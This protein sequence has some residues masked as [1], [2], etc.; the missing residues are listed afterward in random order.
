MQQGGDRR[1]RSASESSSS[2]QN[3]VAMS[4]SRYNDGPRDNKKQ[5]SQIPPRFQQQRSVERSRED[6]DPERQQRGEEGRPTHPQ[7]PPSAQGGP[8]WPMGWPMPPPMGFMPGSKFSHPT[9]V[10]AILYV[11]VAHI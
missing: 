5:H 2:E 9:R 11:Q 1:S 10:A 6:R 4:R 3:S 8:G 7:H